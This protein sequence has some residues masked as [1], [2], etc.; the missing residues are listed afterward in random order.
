VDTSAYFALA[1]SRDAHHDEARVI[2]GNLLSARYRQFTTNVL[3]IECHALILSALGIAPAAQFLR[4]IHASNT[5]IIRVRAQDEQRAQQIVFRYMDKDFSFADAISFVVME[6]LGITHAFTYD[7]YFAQ[8]GY[9]IA[10]P[11]T[12][13]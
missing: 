7:Q 1:D 4:S 5:T 8:F 11:D 12:I 10:S 13:R 2:L 3:I 9:T 6:R